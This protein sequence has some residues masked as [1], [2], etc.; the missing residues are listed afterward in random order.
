MTDL[1]SVKQARQQLIG[2]L[3]P[4][5][6]IE[7]AIEAA[8]HHV[9]AETI[10]SQFDYPAFE[11]SSMDGFAVLAGDV[12]Q[13]SLQYPVKLE[14]VADI[15]A[16]KYD[17]IEIQPGKTARIMTGAPLPPGSN[18]VV[19]IESTDQAQF[20]NLSP[21]PP[22][23]QVYSPVRS[24]DF[25]RKRGI[26]FS[27]GSAVLEQ[28]HILAS[29]DIGLLAS[30]GIEKVKVY[31]PIRVALF[32]SGD[33]LVPVERPLSPGK[34]HDSNSYTLKGLLLDMGVQVFHLGVAP[35]DRQGIR[36][37]LQKAVDL[38]V[39]LILSTAG[40]SVG[41]F[42]FLREVVME[43]GNIDF[44]RVNMRPGKPIAFGNY[45]TITFIGLPGNPVSAY[46]GFLVFGVPAIQKMSGSLPSRPLLLSAILKHAIESDGRESYL[47]AK[48][49]LEDGRLISELTG[50]QG[51]GNLLSLVQANALLIVPSGVKSLPAGSMVDLLLLENKEIK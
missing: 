8:Y 7:V 27:A 2:V 24:G 51:S 3:K 9:L 19:P 15:P 36:D 37:I 41:A 6:S 5:N 33:E 49:T 17:P 50:H 12:A 42:D 46:I 20:T 4:V 16:G 48:V 44:W 1:L 14:V 40:V 29:Q 39:D 21:V 31:R 34:I 38:K 18:A 13:A 45:R 47:R 23:V 25:V 30:L 28:G 22:V 43:S 26:D 32:S 10:H 11:N 35:D